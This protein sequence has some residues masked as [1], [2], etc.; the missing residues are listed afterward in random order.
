MNTKYLILLLPVFLLSAN[1]RAQETPLAHT[2][3]K[4]I[5]FATTG[6]GVS[7]LN[8]ALRQIS[9]EGIKTYTG[10]ELQW[11]NHYMVRLSYEIGIYKFDNTKYQNGFK[12][13]NKGNR[14]LWA[15][16]ADIGY[17][18]Y[19][20]KW[21]VYGFGGF[22]AGQFISPNTTVEIINQE[23]K[24]VIL[25]KTH[26]ILRAGAGLEVA[27]RPK[28]M[29]YLELQYGGLLQKTKIN[30]RELTFSNLIIGFKANLNRKN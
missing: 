19:L 22:G 30:N 2:T 5:Q 9:D 23:V 21:S 26:T 14:T 29:P 20:K 15:A 27:I 11:K 12:V 24:T 4:P 18:Q 13:V 28:F 10:I 6:L 16:F 17:R 25:K 7:S 8:K 1:L 3:T